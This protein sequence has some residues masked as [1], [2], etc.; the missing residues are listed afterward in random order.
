MADEAFQVD[1]GRGLGEGEVV[2]SDPSPRLTEH[3][4]C[5]MI[6]SSAQMTEGDA[7]VHGQSLDLVEDGQMRGVVL[8]GPVDPPGQTT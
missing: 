8:I 4:A 1:L 3:D 5:E 2:G 6:K 7:L